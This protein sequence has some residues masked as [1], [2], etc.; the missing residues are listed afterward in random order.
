MANNESAFAPFDL[1]KT[2]KY[3]KKVDQK[4]LAKSFYRLACQYYEVSL[5]T[6]CNLNWMPV[7][8]ANAAFSCELFLKAILY[9]FGISFGNV[10]GLEDLF[11]LLPQKE[12]DFI[13]KNIN[14][15]N[16]ENEFYLCLSEQSKAF[17]EYR[18]MCEA[19]SMAGNPIFLFEFAQILK[20]DYETLAKENGEN[21]D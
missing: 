20:F 2:P 1:S 17:T 14:I 13:A 7:T 9:G 16:R 6:L 21:I 11:K 19:K 5:F 4:H 15:K 3:D 10:H 18:Y 12:Q 8:M